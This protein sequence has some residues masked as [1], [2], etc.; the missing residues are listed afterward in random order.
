[1]RR[2]PTPPP[3]TGTERDCIAGN[4]CW[5]ADRDRV[6]YGFGVGVKAG[7]TA[8]RRDAWR[9]DRVLARGMSP[10]SPQLSPDGRRVAFVT[11]DRVDPVTLK[12]ESWIRVVGFRGGRVRSIAMVRDHLELPSWT[13]DSRFI[14]YSTAVRGAPLGPGPLRIW[15]VRAAGGRPR[16]LGHGRAPAPSR[17]GRKVAFAID[18]EVWTMNA[19]GSARR[20]IARHRRLDTVGRISWSPDG[21]RIAYIL[22][23]L[24]SRFATE[25][26]MVDAGGG[27]SRRM[28]LPSLWRPPYSFD[29]SSG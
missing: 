20:R 2:F 3:F 23:S 1:M 5:S 16:L 28:R 27:R 11:Q 26:R 18:N 12:S 24:G 14:L 25:I 8:F 9:R 7:S 19:D 21:R 15:R 22:Y 10:Q 4:P 13:P 17:D 6:A 29:W